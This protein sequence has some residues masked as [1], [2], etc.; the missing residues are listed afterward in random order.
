LKE[1]HEG[2]FLFCI[3]LVYP[4]VYVTAFYSNHCA[5]STLF[6][7]QGNAG[8][9]LYTGD[10]RAEY[11]FV[12]DLMPLLPTI[13]HLYLDTTFYHQDVKWLPTKVGCGC[14]L[15]YVGTKFT[16]LGRCYKIYNKATLFFYSH[17][18]M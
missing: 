10:M 12:Q 9:V 7:I 4:S 15:N 13:D 5:G 16:S 14:Q 11:P 17:D 6:L 18:W 1:R 2:R 3:H 8:T